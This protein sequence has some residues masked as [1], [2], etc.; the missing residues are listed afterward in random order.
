MLWRGVMEVLYYEELRNQFNFES[1][2]NTKNALNSHHGRK[3][4]LDY[5]SHLST[6]LIS[7]CFKRGS[8]PSFCS[9]YTSIPEFLNGW[10]GRFRIERYIILCCDNTCFESCYGSWGCCLWSSI[11]IKNICM[12]SS[13]ALCKSFY[14]GSMWTSYAV[15]EKKISHLSREYRAYTETPIGMPE[16][17]NRS[18]WSKVCCVHKKILESNRVIEVDMKR[19]N[20]AIVRTKM[21]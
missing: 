3:F 16:S 21:I 19:D 15:V 5:S 2:T 9:L 13:L 14:I 7:L 18:W 8:I 20:F 6:E 17:I 10:T 4:S 1:I 11:F 12:F